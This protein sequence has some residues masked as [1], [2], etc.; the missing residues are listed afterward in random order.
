MSK[1]SLYNDH[2]AGLRCRYGRLL[3]SRGLGSLIIVVIMGL[4][5]GSFIAFVASASSN[6]RIDVLLCTPR[7]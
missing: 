4:G 2:I 6:F 1:T 5:I 3:V 7:R